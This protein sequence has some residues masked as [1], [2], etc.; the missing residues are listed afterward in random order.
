[1]FGCLKPEPMKTEQTEV[2]LAESIFRAELRDYVGS[3]S[4][5]PWLV[6]FLVLLSLSTVALLLLLFET[7]L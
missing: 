3:Y 4:L 5:E 2:D 6:F 7:S 1:M